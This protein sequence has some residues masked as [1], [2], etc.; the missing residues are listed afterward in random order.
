MYYKL[1]N[2][3]LCNRSFQFKIGLNV[4][5]E[6]FNPNHGCVSGGFYFCNLHDLG[7]WLYLYPNGLIFEVILPE[8]V[9]CVHQ[10]RKYKADKISIGNPMNII[11]FIKKHNV[12]ESYIIS[13]PRNLQHIDFTSDQNLCITAIK[14]NPNALALIPPHIQTN[15]MCLTA[16]KQNGNLLMFVSVQFPELCLAAVQQNGNALVYVKIQT[17]SIC[18]AAVNQNGYSLAYVKNQTPE[19]CLAAVKQNGYAISFVK[20]LTSE[21]CDSAIT[22]NEN[23]THYDSLKS[24]HLL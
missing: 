23:V 3:D 2:N 8:D 12:A 16:I 9:V 6:P 17:H 22:Q 4:L 5:I 7:F 10:Y 11:A 19:L 21:I 18:L 14:H 20:I 13:D 1:I 15:D 24:F